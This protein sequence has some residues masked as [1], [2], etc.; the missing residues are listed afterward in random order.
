M[1]TA[2][3]PPPPAASPASPAVA[4]PATTNPSWSRWPKRAILIVLLIAAVVVAIPPATYWVK[5]RYGH[6]LTDDAFIETHI[7]N[8]APEAVSGHIVRFTADD[9]DRVEA[10]Q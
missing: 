10:G 6:S 9:N 1:S 7:V 4:P 8:I 5:Y 3:S 2:P